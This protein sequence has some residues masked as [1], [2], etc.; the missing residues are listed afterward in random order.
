MMPLES[1]FKCRY[2]E[3]PSGCWRWI[4]NIDCHGYGRIKSG[5]KSHK[6]H[7]LS[8]QLHKGDIPLGLC[9]CHICDHTW[10]V[11]PEHLF[12]GT[13]GENTLDMFSKGRA[14]PP[15]GDHHWS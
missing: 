1:Q 15:K 11:N 10:C 6:A 2:V 12:L 13:Y 9:V 14:N 8:W 5:G 3:L 4:G 7:R